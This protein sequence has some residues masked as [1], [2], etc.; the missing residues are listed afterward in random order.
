MK[1]LNQLLL[2]AKL[3]F[4]ETVLTRTSLHEPYIWN[5]E[6]KELLNVTDYRLSELRSYGDLHYDVH[7][8]IDIYIYK[9]NDV[10]NFII[11]FYG[12]KTPNTNA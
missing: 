7:Q 2:L 12:P 5:H 9:I 4:A 3:D 11:K 10:R 1:N 8:R 6:L